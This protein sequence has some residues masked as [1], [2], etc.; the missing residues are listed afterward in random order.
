MLDNIFL[1]EKH[2]KNTFKNLISGEI[3]EKS[4]IKILIGLFI[5]GVIII[6]IFLNRT[7][8]KNYLY[9]IFNVIINSTKLIFNYS[10]I[11]IFL[12][13]IFSVFQGFFPIISLLIM[14]K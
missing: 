12:C 4:S 9:Q 5:I 7:K 8:T 10:W 3:M 6:L 13:I 1:C 2:Q 11:Y 14:Q